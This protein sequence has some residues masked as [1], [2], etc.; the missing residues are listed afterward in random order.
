MELRHKESITIVRNVRNVNEKLEKKQGNMRVDSVN[1]K[2]QLC[3]LL[4][5]FFFN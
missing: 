4:I 1:L 3:K 5:Y 2:K